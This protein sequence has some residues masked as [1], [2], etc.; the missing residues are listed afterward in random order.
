M[1]RQLRHGAG[2]L[3]Q[4]GVDS[5]NLQRAAV[6]DGRAKRA[7]TAEDAHAQHVLGSQRA[8]GVVLHGVADAR[9]GAAAQG[10]QRCG[11]AVA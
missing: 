9:R 8:V 1:Q 4:A 6:G 3:G 5:A 2:Q 10:L 11:D 7:A